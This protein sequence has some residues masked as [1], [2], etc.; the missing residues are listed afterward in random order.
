MNS[1]HGFIL[2]KNNSI[3]RKFQEIYTEALSFW[4]NCNLALI[5]YLYLISSHVNLQFNPYNFKTLYLFNRN[6]VLSDFY[7]KRF[8]ATK[9]I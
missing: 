3:S 7:A 9:P 6:S 2:R 8:V 4:L 1:G 5:F